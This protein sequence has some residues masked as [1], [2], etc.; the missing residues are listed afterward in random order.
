MKNKGTV[1]ASLILSLG[2][3]FSSCQIS[4]STQYAATYSGGTIPTGVYM[5]YCLYNASSKVINEVSQTD[6]EL[7]QN[8]ED[9]YNINFNGNNI[10]Q[11]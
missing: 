10:I 1:L 5:M 9:V 3:V 11:C 7:F 6:P 4:N 2:V 8:S